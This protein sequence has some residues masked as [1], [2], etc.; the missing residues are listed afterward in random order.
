ML[1][2]SYQHVFSNET[3]KLQLWALKCG[4]IGHEILCNGLPLTKKTPHK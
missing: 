2:P 3:T 1:T 4:F